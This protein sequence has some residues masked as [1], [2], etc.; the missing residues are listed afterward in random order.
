MTAGTVAPNLQLASVAVGVLGILLVY[1]LSGPA[2]D[3][4]TPYLP[5]VQTQTLRRL[6][7]LPLAASATLIISWVLIQSFVLPEITLL[8]QYID[9]YVIP[10][11]QTIGA[12]VW[13]PSLLR[14]GRGVIRY[15]VDTGRIEE[16]IAP[17]IQNIWSI[18]ILLGGAGVLLSIWG[19]DI[20]PLLASAGV[21]GIIL[22]F[23]A[24]ATIAN[25]LAS[26]ALYADNTYQAGDF[27]AI[28]NEDVTGF[29]NDVTIRSTTLTTLDGNVVTIPNST[30]NEAIITN[31]SSPNAGRR[32]RLQVG[33][34][35]DVAPDRVKEL[36]LN[37]ATENTLV[38]DTPTPTVHLRD[39]GDSAIIFEL[40]VWIE[41]PQQTLVVEDE[42]NVAIQETLADAGITMPYPQRVVTL[43]DQSTV[44]SQEAS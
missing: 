6:F 29:V 9:P 16:A 40:L 1:V 33:V 3:R 12:V 30:L 2:I 36:L 19:I 34:S 38:R 13:L 27:I 41:R 28:E 11:F 4:I 35:Y 39:F 22:G 15:A 18:M 31:Q 5:G 7:R 43:N 42:L 17:I 44:S 26:L 14:A 8:R 21:L 25:F 37:V 10:V 20:T 24:R 23:A 32:L